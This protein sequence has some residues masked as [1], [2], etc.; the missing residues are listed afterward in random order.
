MKINSWAFP[1]YAFLYAFGAIIPVLNVMNIPALIF[2]A[3]YL[4]S[5]FSVSSDLSKFKNMIYFHLLG[6]I[7]FP[8][9][10]IRERNVIVVAILSIITLNIYWLYLLIKLTKEISNFINADMKIR[11]HLTE[12]LK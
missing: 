1:I 6:G 7:P 11:K 8:I 12:T 4:H 2:L 3:I 9:P 10:E 5:L